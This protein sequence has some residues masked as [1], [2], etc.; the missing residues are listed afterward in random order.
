MSF[1]CHSLILIWVCNCYVLACRI[2][3]LPKNETFQWIFELKE[4]KCKQSRKGTKCRIGMAVPWWYNQEEKNYLNSGRKEKYLNFGRRENY[5][6][7]DRLKHSSNVGRKRAI[8]IAG[9][10]DC[11]KGKNDQNLMASHSEWV[12]ESIFKNANK[13]TYLF[14]KN[15]YFYLRTA[16]WLPHMPLRRRLLPQYVK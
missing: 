14:S 16:E 3:L 15:A 9:S 1:V 12:F 2:G 7:F 5:L 11:S 8:W 4:E 6:N 13:N 10:F